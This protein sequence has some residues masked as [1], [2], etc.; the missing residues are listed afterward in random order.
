MGGRRPVLCHDDVEESLAKVHLVP[1]KGNKL[2]NPETVPISDQDEGDVSVAVAHVR[3]QT[4]SVLP[5]LRSESV[6][7]TDNGNLSH[8]SRNHLSAHRAPSPR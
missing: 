8:G 6:Q 1:A 2:G 4:S 7:V 5:F 3:R